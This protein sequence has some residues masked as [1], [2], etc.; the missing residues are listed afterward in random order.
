MVD[1]FSAGTYEGEGTGANGQPVVHQAVQ[2]FANRVGV[3]MSQ[4]RKGTDCAGPRLVDQDVQDACPRAR[5]M[6]PRPAR[7][8]AGGGPRPGCGHQDLTGVLPE[9]D[10]RAMPHA[11]RHATIFGAPHTTRSVS[12]LAAG[13]VRRAARSG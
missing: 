7:S 4:C 9:L 8:R 1:V 12:A 5:E 13:Q 10:A 6:D 11:I 3:L 2:M